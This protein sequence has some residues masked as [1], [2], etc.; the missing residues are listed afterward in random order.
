MLEVGRR[1][2]ELPAV[3]TVFGFE[4]H[5]GRL[6]G[7]ARMVE[8]PLTQIDIDRGL[9]EDTL[10]GAYRP[11][12]VSTPYCSRISRVASRDAGPAC[13]S[14]G[15]SGPQSAHSSVPAP[16]GQH[17][18]VPRSARCTARVSATP[19][20]PGTPWSRTLHLGH[21]RDLRG[22]FGTFGRQAIQALPQLDEGVAG[23]T[24]R[25]AITARERPIHRGPPNAQPPRNGGRARVPPRRR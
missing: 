15:V 25:L 8:M 12:G 13:W 9:V 19:G 1:H 4:T 18:G 14:S 2:I 6:A 5:R 11:L 7:E 20:A 16:P 23:I 3:I 10:R 21:R 24:L 17:A 22:P